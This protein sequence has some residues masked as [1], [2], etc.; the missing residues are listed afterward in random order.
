MSDM[1]PGTLIDMRVVRRFAHY[2]A[3]ERIAVPMDQAQDLA[4]RRLAQPL[5]L[6][7]PSVVA[8]AESKPDA[9]RQPAQMVRK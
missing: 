1:V 4:A 2:N 5:Q 6:L 9:T 3:G 8:S 7:V